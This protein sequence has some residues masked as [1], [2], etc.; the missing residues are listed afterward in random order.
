MIGYLQGTVL[1]NTNANALILVGGVGY[2]VTLL[3]RVGSVHAVGCDAS[4]FIAPYVRDGALELYGFDCEDDMK[5]FERLISV[6]GVGP[7]SALAVLRLAPGTDIR[8]AIVSG[9]ADMLKKVS[10]IGGKT[11]QRIVIELRHEFQESPLEGGANNRDEIVDALVH[12]GYTRVA[13]RE[14]AVHI[15]ET[16]HTPEE[17]IRAALK[18]IR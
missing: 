18:N 13:A 17:M 4:F 16:A 12:L 1:A 14:A 2:R 5:L 8:R 3:E 6:S 15:P 11:A 9:D 7:K 10:G